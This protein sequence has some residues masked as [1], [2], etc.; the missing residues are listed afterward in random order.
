M[1]NS[2][3][4]KP[5]CKIV[6]DAM[7]GDY[8]P[9][10]AV[11]GAVEAARENKSIKI[12]LVGQIDEVKNVLSG[13]NIDPS[14]YEIIDSP[15]IIG[16]NENPVTALKT[17]PNSSIS[18]SAKMVCDGKADAFISA[19]NTGAVVA[20]ATLFIRRIKGVERPTIGT[21][22]P[23]ESGICTLFD[24]GAF[25]D[26][27]PQHLLSYA[28]MANIYVEEIYGIKN[29]TI[30]LLSVGEEDEKGNKLTKEASELL[31][32]SNL[33]FVGNVE[34]R[35]ILKGTTNI[36]I[37]DGFI[38]NIL[39]KFGESVPRL[40]KH[41]LTEYAKK[42]LFQKL[43]IGLFKNSLKAALKPLDYQGYGGVPLLGV[44]GITII[45]HGSS[46]PLAIKNMIFR[47]KEMY[48]KNLIEKIENSLKQF[49]AKNTENKD[50]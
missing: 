35:D 4:T 48:D 43:K 16:M 3:K 34:G 36:V 24:V 11:L 50:E 10:N 38:G 32:K 7:G 17:K 23:N 26:S 29:P 46:T 8:A 18:I 45:G 41:L 1:S 30:G 9:R 12:I 44:N 19:G 22:I 2:D 15:D 49:Q 27:K 37:C 21:F 33:N 31:K 42:S 6:V 20:A 28:F 40:M 14:G 47:A 13:N 39:L 5:V 25:V